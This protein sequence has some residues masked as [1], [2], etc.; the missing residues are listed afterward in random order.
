M[1]TSYYMFHNKTVKTNRVDMLSSLI[2]YYAKIDE[3]PPYPTVKRVLFTGKNLP[4]LRKRL[5]ESYESYVMVSGRRDRP[6][7]N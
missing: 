2:P 6:D 4:N 1:H 7:D 3:L 5:E